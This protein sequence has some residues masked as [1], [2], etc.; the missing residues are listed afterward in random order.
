MEDLIHKL[1]EHIGY[2][3]IAIITIIIVWIT[4]TI[5][6]ILGKRKK[7]KQESISIK[8]IK[9]YSELDEILTELRVLSDSART[10][11]IQFH[12][13]EYFY[14]GSPILKF[15][16]THESVTRG[17]SSIIQKIQGYYLSPY[18]EIIQLSEKPFEINNINEFIG[19]NLKGFFDVHNT[20]SF[21][22]LPIKCHKNINIIGILLVEWC[23]EAK[24]NKINKEEV[25]ILCQK[26]LTLIK[27][28]LNN[29]NRE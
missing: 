26:Y 28:I 1:G 7:R 16:M 2:A 19:S 9:I 6:K 15:S 25:K 21:V 29:K 22:I 12:N 3:I 27:N 14:N 20:I 5:K 24:S 17:V 11:I 13:G 10:S 23:S 4:D 18:Y 8:N